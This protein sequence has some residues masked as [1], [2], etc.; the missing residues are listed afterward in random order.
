MRP[1]LVFIG[2]SA[3]LIGVY[4]LLEDTLESPATP[5]LQGAIVVII[6]A[7]ATWYRQSH[8]NPGVGLMHNEKA[9]VAQLDAES[10]QEEAESSVPPAS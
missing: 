8:T 4:L 2:L 6:L 1:R 3:V 9:S 5:L 7:V 10:A